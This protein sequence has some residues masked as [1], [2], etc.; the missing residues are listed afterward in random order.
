MKNIF[1]CFVASVLLIFFTLCENS[2]GQ[3]TSLSPNKKLANVPG[4]CGS[5][6]VSLK[7]SSSVNPM[8]GN[9]T[10]GQTYNNTACGLN[11]VYD[12]AHIETRYFQATGTLPGCGGNCSWT[13][14]GLPSCYIIDKAFVWALVSYVNPTPPSGSVTITNPA[15]VTN[16]FAPATGT[17]I[18]TDQSK[19]WTETGSCTYRY[20]VTS[21]ISGNGIYNFS[22]TGFTGTPLGY[23]TYPYD[24]IDGATLLI[25]YKDPS[26]SYQGTLD[27]WDGAIVGIGT[28]SAMTMTG[29]NV[30]ATPTLGRA[31][32][33]SSDHQPNVGATH[34][35]SLN[36]VPMNFP[37]SFYNEDEAAVTL[38]SG[39]TTSSFDMD[40]SGGSDCYLWGVMGLYYQTTTCTTCT[41]SAVSVSVTATNAIC[42][43][44]NGTATATANGTPPYTYFWSPG[45]QTTSSIS[46]L[47]P[48]TYTVTVTDGTGCSTVTSVVVGGS[49]AL[50]ITIGPNTTICA[51]GSVN[52]NASGA[53][54]YTWSPTSTLNNSSISNPTA[55]PT[56]NTTYTVSG[57]DSNGCTGTATVSITLTI[58]PAVTAS[59]NATICFGDNTSLSANSNPAPS[60]YSWSPGNGLSCTTCPNPI[61][62]PSFSNTYTVYVTDIYN[63]V[64]SATVSVS[65]G[66]IPVVAA[67]GSTTICPGNQATLNANANNGQTPYS[68]YWSPP[69][70]LNNPNSQNPIATPNTTTI[71]T[72][73][74]TDANGCSADTSTTIYV[75]TEPT[76]AMAPWTPALSCDGYV[77]PFGTNGSS[78]AVSYYWDFG[79]GTNST[80]QNNIH[81]YP[82]NGNYVVTLVVF[83]PP[84]RDS[85][86][87]T[88]VVG[89]MSG[90]INVL[91]A[92]VFTPNGDGM[93]DCFHPAI[94]PTSTS[95]TPAVIDTLADCITI[96]VYDRWGV[97]MFESTDTKK[98]WDGKTKGGSPANEG[99]YFYLAKFGEINL[100]GTVTLLRK[101]H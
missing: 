83:N 23:F 34:Q 1:T 90:F 43:N 79:D 56:T 47:S 4:A 66:T 98:C 96:E 14:T 97:K 38:T 13:I 49:T 59:G 8:D 60:G 73:T 17:A 54:T 39:Q 67:I 21:C 68:F 70:N 55:T 35:T 86:D 65:V 92:N 58:P 24:Q 77:V 100:K 36:G 81:S 71:Y 22:F 53:S 3:S 64:S 69:N 74:V 26:A 32:T 85:V 29:L 91:P 94:T 27:I 2:F 99:T 78:N 84:C 76:A 40:G 80:Q 48:G 18:G 87:T 41:P 15:A 46:N 11:Y 95:I 5:Q 44:S 62:T 63:C 101:K 61:A 50:P 75:G 30:C 12:S 45:G 7:N 9:I 51:G 16:T 52:L 25:I 33:I 37:N 31:F 42:G 6:N 93:N 89:D 72:V 88:I 82:F 28:T 19:C 20:D 10:L 57:T